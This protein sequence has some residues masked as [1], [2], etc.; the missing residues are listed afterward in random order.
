MWTDY[1]AGWVFRLGYSCFAIVKWVLCPE[2]R[3]KYHSLIKVPRFGKHRLSRF[4]NKLKLHANLTKNSWKKINIRSLQQISVCHARKNVNN[5]IYSNYFLQIEV[6]I[7][8]K[9][10]WCQF[11]FDTAFFYFQDICADGNRWRLGV[12]WITFAKWGIL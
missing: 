3:Q 9:L 2:K 11:F 10:K 7:S 8:C 6:I 4:C 1:A 12:K 5:I